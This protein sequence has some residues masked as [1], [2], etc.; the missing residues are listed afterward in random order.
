[1]LLPSHVCVIIHFF[2]ILIGVVTM[3]SND[4]ESP[5]SDLKFIQTIE[6]E[7]ESP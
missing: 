1:M 7:S 2:S 6:I 5:K 4:S 3:S